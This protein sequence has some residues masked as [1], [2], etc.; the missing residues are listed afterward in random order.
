MDLD[1]FGKIAKADIFT[2]SPRWSAIPITCWRQSSAQRCLLGL[3]QFP[4][5]ARPF[6]CP[7]SWQI[8]GQLRYF[9]Q[10]FLQYFSIDPLPRCIVLI[11]SVSWEDVILIPLQGFHIRTFCLKGK[12]KK[13]TSDKER[14]ISITWDIYI[15]AWRW[16][17]WYISIPVHV[18]KNFY[19]VATTYCLKMNNDTLRLLNGY[20]L[21]KEQRVRFSGYTTG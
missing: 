16:A 13:K 15:H 10:L 9:E 2:T 3:G 5:D 20:E 6:F 21:S 19:V 12:R 4:E 14:L 7:W 8:S 17:T 18:A 11:L 1:G